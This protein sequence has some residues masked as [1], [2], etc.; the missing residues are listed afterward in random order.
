MVFNKVID[1]VLITVIGAVGIVLVLQVVAALFPTLQTA[2]DSWNIT[3]DIGG[4]SEL[5]LNILKVLIPL[6]F[7]FAVI[8]YAVDLFGFRSKMSGK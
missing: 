6:V 3:I 1:K 5:D 2:L 4:G 8:A 7:V